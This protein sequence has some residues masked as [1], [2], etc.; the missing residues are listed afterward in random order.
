VSSS[1]PVAGDSGYLSFDEELFM[2]LPRV[3]AGLS[4]V[5]RLEPRPSPCSNSSDDD[6]SQPVL[7]GEDCTATTRPMLTNRLEVHYVFVFVSPKTQQLTIGKRRN[8]TNQTKGT[9]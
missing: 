6:V 1:E 4:D 9:D 8:R 5:T 3:P 2:E 7:G